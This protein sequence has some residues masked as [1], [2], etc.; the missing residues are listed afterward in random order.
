MFAMARLVQ[1]L[2]GRSARFSSVASHIFVDVLG[3]VA[4]RMLDGACVPGVMAAFV[5]VSPL[6]RGVR[7]LDIGLVVVTAPGHP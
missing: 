4:R 3:G 6:L 7:L 2:S 1:A 5:E